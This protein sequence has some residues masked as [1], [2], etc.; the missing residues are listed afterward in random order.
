VQVK[1]TARRALARIPGD[2]RFCLL[3]FMIGRLVVGILAGLGW[4]L[5]HETPEPATLWAPQPPSHAWYAAFTGLEHYDASWYLQ[6]ASH[7]YRDGDPSSAYFPLYPGLV[8]GVGWLCGGRWLLGAYLVGHA[9]LLVALV[10]LYRLTA[11]ELSER[12]A[13]W[14]VVL[15][16]ASPVAFFLYAPYSEP[17]FLALSLAC[18]TWLREG[19]WVHAAGAALLASSTRSTGVVLG[20]AMVAQALSDHGFRLRR[21]DLRPVALKL[22]AS[23]TALA[24][25]IAYLLYWSA[26]GS[27]DAPLTAQRDAFQREPAWPWVSLV[28]GLEIARDTLR[29]PGWL[30]TNVEVVLT[31]VGIGLGVVAVPRFPGPYKALTLA[32]LIMP[33]TL[34]RPFSPLTSVPRYYLVVFPLF[35]ALA[36]VTRRPAVRAAVLS[37]STCLLVLLTLL[38]ASWHDVL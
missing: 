30:I 27:W 18:L 31:L 8:H 15:L 32:S 3:A 34:A 33:L 24:G 7:G 38:F 25:T 11:R 5:P 23:L 12:T 13:R 10:L 26:R 22:A 6:L 29:Y 19:R 35:W 17:L 28:H 37:T 1:V 4:Q 2:V 9:A 20:A 16:L 14:T 21:P 36:E